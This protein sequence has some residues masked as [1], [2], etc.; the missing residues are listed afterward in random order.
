M[1]RTLRHATLR[2]GER[3]RIAALQAPA[4]RYAH[5][6]R[7]FLS[8]KGQPWLTHVDLANQG[9]VDDLETTYYVGFL[10]RAIA[11]NVMIVGDGRVG[12]LGHVFTDPRHRRKGICCELM[13]AAV[14]GFRL[15][16]GLALS[17]GTGHDSPPYRIYHG[18]GFRGI[19]PDNGHMLFE[20]HP[21]GLAR[22]FAPAPVRVADVRWIH[23]AGISLLFMQPE[24][25]AIRSQA[26]GVFGPVGFEGGFLHLQA[27]RE[28]LAVQ[29]KVL[30]TRRGAAVGAAILQ[31][32]PHWP[33]A[34]HTLDLF[35]HPNF[36]GS[37]DPLLRA[38]KLPKEARIQAYL[39]APSA[40]RARALRRHGFR[41]EATLRGQLVRLG[42]ATDVLLY[43]RRT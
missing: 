21:G 8:H 7:Q 5:A 1:I 32:D 20:S 12:I 11:G 19:E 37:E 27:Q 13:A 22:W 18:F 9:Q 24:G 34:I 31:R 28:R 2:T 43:S 23:W 17:L 30:V 35:V 38:L 41:L 14:E 16:G 25:D 3:L 33:A 6:I 15:S 40:G 4:G 10:G 26:Y 39:D 36:E 42:R 29:A